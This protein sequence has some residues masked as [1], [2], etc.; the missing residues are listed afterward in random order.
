MEI[1]AKI[2]SLILS[3]A[4][5]LLPIGIAMQAMQPVAAHIYGA[6]CARAIQDVNV[7]SDD[8]QTLIITYPAGESFEYLTKTENGEWLYVVAK[9]GTQGWAFA[10]MFSTGC[11]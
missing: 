5:G 1:F 9:D 7:Y 10:Q 6:G 4:F 11:G 8:L 2:S 3:I